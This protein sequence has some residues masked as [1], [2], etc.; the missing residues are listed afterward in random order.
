VLC[1]SARGAGSKDATPHSP[2]TVIS[3]PSAPGASS[4]S[5]T[6]RPFEHSR[7]RPGRESFG[8]SFQTLALEDSGALGPSSEA[9][10]CIGT[11]PRRLRP[12]DNDRACALRVAHAI[13]LWLQPVKHLGDL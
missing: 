8:P 3:L 12:W 13:G 2:W 11:A 10:L 1:A 5:A 9:K 4:E 7:V 6:T